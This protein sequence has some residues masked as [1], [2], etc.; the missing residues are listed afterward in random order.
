MSGLTIVGLVAGRELR[1][2]SRQKSF[3]LSTAFIA[4]ALLVAVILPQVLGDD[5]PAAYD[6]GVVGAASA[7]VTSALDSAEAGTGTELRVVPVPDLASGEEQLTE[8]TLDLLLAGGDEVVLAEQVP[9]GSDLGLL[10]AGLAQSLSLSAGLEEAGLAPAQAADVLTRPATPVRNLEVAGA[11]E[12]GGENQP[13]LILGVIILYVTLLTFGVAVATGVVEE[14]STRVVEVLLSA[15]RPHHL[16]AGKILGI[17]VLGLVQLVLVATPALVVS[18]AT[19]ADLP[20]GSALTVASLLLWFVLGYAL[21]SC[22]YA[23]AGS[24]VSRMEEAQ[25]TSFPVTF[26]LIAAYGGAVATGTAPDS[27]AAKILALFPPTAPLAMPTRAALG[28]VARWEVPLAITLTLVTI[29][30]LIRLAGRIYA[31]SVL[32]FGPKVKVRQALRSDRRRDEP[33]SA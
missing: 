11:E 20:S 16:L 26:A 5:G 32:R 13:L 24:L 28:E 9:P 21:Y 4:V 27:T 25:N 15:I 33:A 7:V 22:A 8:G 1:E 2:R 31:G 18:V 30:A 23:A 6:V 19:G 3:K 29:Y 17:G 12:S 14:K 10:S